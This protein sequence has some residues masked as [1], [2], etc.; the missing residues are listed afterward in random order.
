MAIDEEVLARNVL[1]A[2]LDEFEK[3]ALVGLAVE[4]EYSPG[5][6][7]FAENEEAYSVCLLIGGRVGLKLDLGTGRQLIVGTVDEGEL[8]AWS[9]LVPPCQF[10]ASAMAME[11]A[12]VAVFKSEDLTRVFDR[13][14]RLGYAVMR[15]VA[16]VI[17][18]RLR[19]AQLQMIGLSGS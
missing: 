14:P 18:Q 16:F 15:Q 3:A 6:Q 1:F 13:N 8:F 12:R 10:T 17:G 2:N 7:I 19:D 11:P 9:G 4:K 5:E